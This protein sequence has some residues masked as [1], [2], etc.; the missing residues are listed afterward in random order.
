MD[1][2]ELGDYPKHMNLKK[3]DVVLI[4]SDFRK[5]L[6][7]MHLNHKKCDLNDFLDGLIGEIGEDGTILIPTYNWD[8]CKGLPF[9]IRSSPSKTGSLGQISLKRSDFSRTS[10]PIYSFSVFGK[11]KDYFCKLNNTDS[12][13]EDSPF[14]VLKD[15]KC[16]NY[17]IDVSLKHFLTYVHYVEQKS[18]CVSYRYIKNFTAEYTDFNGDVSTRTYSMFVRDLDKNVVN[19]IDPL[20]SDF[21]NAR[22]ETVFKIN[23]S[24][25]KLV[26]LDK[27]HEIILNDIKT[28]SSKKICKYKGQR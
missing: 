21:L 20:E 14:S 11:Y 8:F 17:A 3:N 7:D 13:G 23:S 15:L 24:E 19:R 4:S 9:D 6:W 10:H 28:N 16:K 27:A 12:F 2:I 18:K 1:F 26:Y 25:V 5:V 22:A